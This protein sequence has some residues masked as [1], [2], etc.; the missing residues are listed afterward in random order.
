MLCRAVGSRGQLFVAPLWKGAVT[1]IGKSG[2]RHKFASWV[3]NQKIVVVTDES[4]EEEVVLY[5]TEKEN[6]CKKFGK[7]GEWGYIQELLPDPTGKYVAVSVASKLYILSLDHGKYTMVDEANH[8]YFREFSWSPDGK[9]LAYAKFEGEFNYASIYLY[10]LESKKITQLTKEEA[11]DYCPCFDPKGRYLYFLSKRV[12][13]PYGDSLQNDYNFPVTARPYMIVLKASNYSPFSSMANLDKEEEAEKKPEKKEKGKSG[14][15]KGKP[16]DVKVEIDLEGIQDR[17]V[18][19]PMKEGRYFGLSAVEDKVLVIHRPLT[20]ELQDHSYFQENTGAENRLL[21][22]DLKDQKEKVLV[23]K[24]SSF[25]HAY[26]YKKMVLRIDNKLRIVKSG[27]EVKE[28]DEKP[29]KEGGWI[30]LGRFKVMVSPKAEWRQMMREAWRWQL[31]FYWREDMKGL[32]WEKVYDKYLPVLDKVRT[33]LELNDLFWEMYGETGTSHAYVLGGDVPSTPY[34]RVGTLAVDFEA[35]P[36]SGRYKIEKIYKGDPSNRLRRSPLSE[37]GMNVKE[38]DY[39]LAVNGQEVK[40]PHHPY[41]YLVHLAGSDVSLKISSAPDG[42]NSREITV[43]ALSS[44][45]PVRYH[46]WV[47]ENREYIG[48]KTEGMVGYLHIPDMDVAGLVN[49]HRDFLWQFNKKGLIVDLRYN[50]GGHVSQV[51]LSKLQRKVLGY[52]KPRKGDLEAYPYQTLSGPIV[53]LCDEHTG[54]DGDIFCQAFKDLKL[55]TLIGKRTWGGVVGIQCDKRLVDGGMLTQPEFAFWFKTQ[56]WDIENRGVEPD[57]EV[58]YAPSDYAQGKDPQLERAI[59]EIL[60]QI[61]R[62]KEELPKME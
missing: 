29:G 33:R 2:I 50:A 24:I 10:S 55:G 23:K 42:K 27:E 56:G 59:A 32:D 7:I 18:E 58:D 13:N 1:T 49:F 46:Q 15:K 61:E 3:D 44:E 34:Y 57:I 38:G 41:A 60:K 54:S 4:G 39:L 21:S 6:A 37:P 12:F 8:R 9:W 19:I 25:S 53:A 16:E 11:H 30:D 35:D 31:H 5:D 52:C 62:F 51:I 14:K 45:L 22:Y 28:E 36:K 40:V 17:I 26:P 20:G 43:N 47:K 48:E